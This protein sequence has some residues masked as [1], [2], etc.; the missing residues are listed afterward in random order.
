MEEKIRAQINMNLRKHER[1][2]AIAATT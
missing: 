1:T 2:G